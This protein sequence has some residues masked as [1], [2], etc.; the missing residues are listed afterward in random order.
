MRAAAQPATAPWSRLDV[1]RERARR[2]LG[3]RDLS[4]AASVLRQVIGS[5]P[6][7]AAAHND[8]GMVHLL[9]H[10]LTDAV[11]CFEQSVALDPRMAIAHCNLGTALERQGKLAAAARAYQQAV[12]IAPQLV[13]A[14]ERLGN[15]L[16]SQG[17]YEQAHDRFRRVAQIVPNSILGRLNRAKVLHGEAKLMEAEICLRRAIELDPTNSEAHR[18][19]GNVLRE[20]GRFDEA[21]A[22]FDRTIA[23]NPDET[24]V[25]HDLVQSKRF[26]EADRP[27]VERM[28][29]LLNRSG[30]TDKD[31][32]V[33]HFALGKAFDDLA[34]YERAIRHFDEANRLARRDIRFDRAQFALGV[35][36]LIGSFTADFFAAHRA[37]GVDSE[38]PVL[39]LGMMRSGTTLVEQ[40]LSSHPRV[41]AGEELWFWGERAGAYARSGVEGQ[42]PA[43]LRKLAD[44]Y[45]ALL[46]EIGPVAARITD[47]MP[48]NYLWLGLIHL[49]FPKAFV[50]HCRRHPVDT[51]L[52]I[53]AT[54]F[55]WQID[56]AYDRSDIVFYYRQYRR[57][58]AHWRQ[59]IPSDRFLDV[60]YEELVAN[61]EE[62]TRRLIAFI[63]LD[64]DDA[65]LRPESNRRPVKTASMWQ[66]RQPVY[67]TSVE[68]W[69]RYEPWLGEFRQ[70]LDEND[71]SVPARLDPRPPSAEREAA[72]CLLREGKFSEAI[73]VLQRAVREE[74]D[75]AA[76]NDLGLLLL[77]SHRLD[78]A[79]NNFERAIALDPNLAIAHYNLAAAF[80]RQRCHQAAIAAY[81]R[82]LELD[83][84]LAAAQS[85]LGGMLHAAGDR[86]GALDCYAKAAEVSADATLSRLNRAKY[87]LVEERL[88]EA[89]ECLG[90]TVSDD[91][92]SSE[93]HRLLGTILRESGRFDAAAACLERS[94]ALDPQRIS[95]YHD[96]VQSK[97]V[98]EADRPLM[99]RMTSLIGMKGF[100]D[101]ERTLLHFALGK[102]FDDLTDYE[103]AIAHFDAGNR[104][105]RAG[106]SFDRAKFAEEV[107]R[108]I[109]RFT[110]DFFVA[111]EAPRSDVATPVLIL[112]MPRSG[113]TLVEQ[114]VSSHPQVGAAGELA[115]WSDQTFPHAGLGASEVSAL[116]EQ[117][118][119]LLRRASPNGRRVTDKNPFNFL[120]IGL[121]HL[122]FPRGLI[123]HCNRNPID[124]CLSIYFTR[125]ASPQ[126]FAYDR[127]D[128]VFYYQHYARL[129]A[130]WR[131]VLPL[132]RIFDLHYEDL[133]SH[134]EDVTRRLVAFLGLEWDE[135]CLRP[136]DNQRVIKTASL[137]QARQPVYH[138]A[139]GRWRHYE[140]WLGEL[141]TL[142]PE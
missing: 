74:Q 82:S 66:A 90:A 16:L 15:L 112:G 28:L 119:A 5:S 93:A 80:E 84:S 103:R 102:A 24:P 19:L 127:G 65:C 86:Q 56:F 21:M 130:H 30:V 99:A 61:R 64:W 116:A 47:K 135:V 53:Y 140:P 124:T 63:G 31:R 29:F 36:R 33:L 22:C 78:E 39:I 132:D 115:F 79:V 44:D 2:L 59:V 48:G 18:F 43:Y 139:V 52:S 107:D 101:H 1:E 125:F 131:R 9:S 10:H 138:T 62:V 50:I 141:R 8:L 46:R 76:Y 77:Y 25:Y 14:H 106:L 17:M 98:T 27:V 60:D 123:I 55:N 7:N 92:D 67:R 38:T 12:N 40:I 120:R 34:D 68:R 49:V 6:G 73:A 91:P 42:T 58:M 111:N 108:M 88:T 85:R 117:Y 128:L 114:I 35:D 129:M 20:L 105:E 113:T 134:R 81:R 109:G 37:S 32:T 133:I 75:P 72:D 136:E 41:A 100:T 83:P 142:V 4:G 69:R 110:P 97:K 96:L 51:C 11:Q 94:I 71:R 121:F 70:L 104:L 45:L 13:E 126:S 54:N 57:L 122:V 118:L 89:E 26:T 87:L 95:A 23:L 3:A 137:W